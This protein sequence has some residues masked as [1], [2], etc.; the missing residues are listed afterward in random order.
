MENFTGRQLQLPNE[1]IPYPSQVEDDLCSTIIAQFE[2]LGLAEALANTAEETLSTT[3]ESEEGIEEQKN[4]DQFL[5]EFVSQEI[6]GHQLQMDVEME[7]DEQREKRKNEIMQTLLMKYYMRVVMKTD[8]L[9][10]SYL[11]NVMRSSQ[12]SGGFY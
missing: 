4:R 2:K 9:N 10:Q 7:T 11:Q 3:D 6:R 8:R 1:A 5:K 12:Q